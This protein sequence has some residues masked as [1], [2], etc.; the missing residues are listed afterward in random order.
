MRQSISILV[1]IILGYYLLGKS[2][3]Y[4]FVGEIGL[5]YFLLIFLSHILIR[6]KIKKG[7]PLILYVLIFY[8]LV[9]LTMGFKSHGIDAVRDSVVILYC[10]FAFV[11]YNFFQFINYSA[12]DWI[13]SIFKILK[14]LPIYYLVFFTINRLL[15]GF[16]FIPVIEFNLFSVKPG[17]LGVHILFVTLAF[18]LRFISFNNRY[19]KI[20]FISS[21]IILVLYCAVYNRGGFLAFLI[22][23]IMM[24]IF[25]KKLKYIKYAFGIALFAFFVLWISS[26]SITSKVENFQGRS[27]SVS[28]ITKNFEAIINL[29]DINFDKMGES[30]QKSDPT[31]SNIIWRIIWW[32]KII[33]YTIFGEY[34]WFGKGFGVN[35]S[36]DD[37]IGGDPTLR[38]PHNA[39]MTVL[40]RTGIIGLALWTYFLMSI[41]YRVGRAI[42]Y[43]KSVNKIRELDLLILLICSWTAFLINASFDVFLEN[44][45]GG[46][47]FWVLTGVILVQLTNN[48]KEKVQEMSR[49]TE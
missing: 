14:Y 33:D 12:E 48:K 47:P 28:Q 23:F 44:P 32:I 18:F 43:C 1:F 31:L 6:H 26:Y 15:P 41:Y 27:F 30:R 20:F 29:K 3:G 46:I 34:F 21:V 40:A 42:L 24:L 7:F 19:M 25:K 4:L 13:K 38:S 22:P 9:Q 36:I 11:F 17:D 45:M 8:G 16:L 37:E 5:V 35:L 2:W 49:I 10:L 39:H